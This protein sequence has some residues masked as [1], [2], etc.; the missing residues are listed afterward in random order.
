MKEKW[1]TITH[2]P[3]MKISNM[4]RIRGVKCI[5]KFFLNIDG[6]YIVQLSNS[7]KDKK[8]YL[9]HRLVAEHFRKK[10]KGSNYVDH[11]NH[12]KTD[13]KSINLRWVTNKENLANRLFL[14]TNLLKEIHK[15]FSS[16]KSAVE[17]SKYYHVYHRK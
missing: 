3:K 9:V 14:C 5:R 1:K 16:G 7:T 12:I 17:I 8:T 15:L 6:Y 2:F 13:N 10:K 4:G 11:I